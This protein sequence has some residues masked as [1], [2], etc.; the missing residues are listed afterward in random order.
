MLCT[1]QAGMDR[2]KPER[3]RRVVDS[4]EGK[5]GRGSNVGRQGAA[6]LA[7]CRVG[8]KRTQAGAV[9]KASDKKPKCRPESP[10]C[11]LAGLTQ[12]PEKSKVTLWPLLHALFQVTRGAA[13]LKCGRGT[14]MLL[15]RCSQGG[16]ESRKE[17]GCW[18]GLPL[19]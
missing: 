4:E 18:G 7:E 16:K 2:E 6:S 5:E 8:V 12:P 15:G 3:K 19:P 17:A 10:V 14:A 1:G 9:S 11:S 13:A